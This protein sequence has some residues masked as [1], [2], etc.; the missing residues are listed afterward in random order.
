[1]PIPT[2]ADKS[3]QD[4]YVS[5]V[6][7]VWDSADF[8]QLMRGLNW[9]RNANQLAYMIAD[10]N[11]AMGAGVI[12][13]LSANKRWSENIKLATSAFE[14]GA[15]AGTFGDAIRKA[16]RIMAGESPETVL[17]MGA[18]TGHFYRC[19]LDPNDPEPVCID[20][21]AHDIAV[22]ERY[23]SQDRGLSKKPRYELIANVYREA[24]KQIGVIPQVLQA[25]TWVVWIE[26]KGN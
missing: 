8:E 17:P 23:G 10:G 25:T 2:V 7:S 20:R 11:T 26:R 5:N 18:K 4:Q 9:Y 13:A 3:V 16:S 21:H 19:I 14:N 12:A 24:A 6:I 15:A 22:N 1:M